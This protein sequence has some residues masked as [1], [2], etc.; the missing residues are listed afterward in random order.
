MDLSPL[1][2]STFYILLSVKEEN[3]GYGIIKTVE[4]LTEGR[5]KLAPGTL[6]GALQNLLRHK[7]IVITC[8]DESHKNKKQYLITDVGNKLLMYEVKRISG[9]LNH[10]KQMGVD[11]ND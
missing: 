4:K 7:C 6:Y 1:T 10:S 8:I 11:L 9:M 2:E 5:L 3:H